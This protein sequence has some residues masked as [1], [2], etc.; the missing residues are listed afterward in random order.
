MIFGNLGHTN[1]TMI[2]TKA[3]KYLFG[4]GL[5]LLLIIILLHYP[6]LITWG[7][8]APKAE[9]ELFQSKNGWGY[10]IVMNNKTIIYQPTVPAIDSVMSFPN[11]DSA[12]KIGT[13][14]LKRFI[15]HRNFS[16]SKEE[17]IRELN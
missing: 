12:R 1:M 13:I 11:E 14:V 15:E 5:L 4:G 10:Q 9:L 16:V 2:C 3:G 8:E 6:S 7:E 17:V